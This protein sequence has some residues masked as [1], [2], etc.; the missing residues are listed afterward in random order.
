MVANL[1]HFSCQLEGCTIFSIL[2]LKNGYLQVPLEQSEVPKTA[3]I[4]PIWPL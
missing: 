4:T 1:A 3:V 2:D